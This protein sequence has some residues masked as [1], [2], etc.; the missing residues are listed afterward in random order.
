VQFVEKVPAGVSR[1]AEGYVLDAETRIVIV[2]STSTFRKARQAIDPCGD[3]EA[4]R[5]IAGVLAHE[6][7]HV[8]HG[9]DERGAYDAQLIALLYVGADQNGPLFH[10]VMRAKQAVSAASKRTA[11][12]RALAR[13]SSSAMNK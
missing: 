4:L 10:K 5:E 6:E 3:V 9:P 2:T 12:A 8:R 11:E 13:Q 7:W 1:L